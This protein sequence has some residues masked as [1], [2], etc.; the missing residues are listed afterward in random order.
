MSGVDLVTVT[1]GRVDAPHLAWAE[2]ERVSLPRELLEAT[3]LIR[4]VGAD[5]RLDI[6]ST[7]AAPRGIAAALRDRAAFTDTPPAS[8]R[9]PVSYQLVP[10]WARALIASALGRWQ[11]RSI[12]RWAAFPGFPL[13]LSA[14]FVGDVERGVA[15]MRRSAT[16]VM[17]SHDIDSPEGLRN[18][19]EQFL[20]I[21]EAAGAR[22]VNFIVPC[23]WPIDE[24]LVREVRARGHEIGVH[25]YDHSNRTPFAAADERA[26][27]LDAARPFVE[28]YG[29]CGYRAPSLLRTR[30]LLRGLS[31]IYGY[32]SSIPT[33]GGLFPVPN[34]GCAT[35][36]CG[37]SATRRRRSRRCGATARGG[38]RRPAASSCC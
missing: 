3:G 33:S 10:G 20:P 19:V 32:D 16:P 29:A 7:I 14:D 26:R 28:R 2:G 18:L 30:A 36:A 23:A 38:S 17:V 25:G 8:S 15:T 22:S 34:N 21:E 35:A 11:R 13:D 4:R 24:G 31:A 6:P 12:N 1:V 5:G 9:L 27:R 37:F